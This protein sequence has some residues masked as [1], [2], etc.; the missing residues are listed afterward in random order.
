MTGTAWLHDDLLTPLRAAMAARA[1][2]CDFI[3]RRFGTRRMAALWRGYGL[4]G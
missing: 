3:A 4:I 2:L 1:G